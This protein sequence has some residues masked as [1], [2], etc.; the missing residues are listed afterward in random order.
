[1]QHSC[2]ICQ[3]KF[4]NAVVLQQHIRMHMAGQ[5]PD[6]PHADPH[7]GPISAELSVNDTNTDGFSS[8]E[9]DF[10]DGNSMEDDEEEEDEMEENTE[11]GVDPFRVLNSLT[12]SPPKSSAVVSNIAALENQMKI[13]DSTSG[14]NHT[15]GMKGFLDSDCFTTNSSYTPIPFI[16]KE[17][18]NLSKAVSKCSRSVAASASPGQNISE[19]L[20]SSSSEDTLTESRDVAVSLKNE[21]SSSSPQDQTGT[22]PNQ[23][24]INEDSPYS[25]MFQSREC[26]KVI[27]HTR[28]MFML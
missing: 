28:F 15:F 8:Q 17:A 20:L 4:T 19:G 21:Y 2:P 16:M 11:E 6:S 26:G 27:T 25:M 14:L 12:S 5:I 23:P 22:Q 9:N 7:Q 10:T 1:M 24:S 3:K 18:E 13:I